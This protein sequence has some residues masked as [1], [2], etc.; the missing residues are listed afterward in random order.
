MTFN[1]MGFINNLSYMGL[2][3][4]AIFVVIAIIIGITYLLNFVFSPPVIPRKVQD[5]ENGNNNNNG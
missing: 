5:S 3:M 1:P 2:G 4:L